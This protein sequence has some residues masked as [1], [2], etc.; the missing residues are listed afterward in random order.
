VP[1]GIPLVELKV[2]ALQ[3]AEKLDL[4]VDFGWLSGSPPRQ[5]LFSV[6]AL[7]RFPLCSPVFLC[8][9]VLPVVKTRTYS[10]IK[11]TAEGLPNAPGV[12]QQTV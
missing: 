5:G 1:L 10:S 7:S 9:P 11:E 6:L 8:S 2:P 3:F 12:F 4:E